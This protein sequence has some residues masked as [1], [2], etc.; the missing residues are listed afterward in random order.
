[1]NFSPDFSPD[2]SVSPG[3]IL[4]EALEERN[5]SQNEFVIKSGLSKDVVDDILNGGCL[6]QEISLKFEKVLGI[7]ANFWDQLEKNRK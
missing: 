6:T 4:I 5:M 7:P 2:Y 1:M 3:E